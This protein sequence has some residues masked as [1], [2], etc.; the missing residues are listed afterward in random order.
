MRRIPAMR[1]WVAIFRLFPTL[2][3]ISS[4]DNRYFCYLTQT[5]L[6]TVS[7]HSP[8][9]AKHWQKIKSQ[10]KKENIIT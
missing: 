2:A 7:T 10:L 5:M 1:L 3:K 9:N 4:A 8:R 6:A